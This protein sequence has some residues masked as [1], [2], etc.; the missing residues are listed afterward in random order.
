MSWQRDRTLHPAELDLLD[1]FAVQCSQALQRIRATERERTATTQVRQLAEE[2]QQ[3]LLTPPPGPDHLHVVV[4]YRPAADQAQVG[5]DWYDAFVQPDGA[6][7]LVIGDVVGHDAAAAARMGQL[8]G[9]LRALAYDADG[10]GHD[11][12]AGVLTR[13][14]HAAR[15]LAVDTLATAVL[16]RVERE[17]N[18]AVT[19]TRTVRWSNAGHLPPV[20]VH[21]DG[22]SE[23]L[24]TDAD[25]MLGVDAGTPRTDHTVRLPDHATLLLFTDGLVERRDASLDRGLDALGA[26]VTDLGEAPLD[27]LCDTL[28]ARLAPHAGDD[29]IALVAVRGYPENRPRS[30]QAAPNRTPALGRG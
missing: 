27:K 20:L 15:G 8:R 16:A 2:L 7:M 10:T 13:V 4:R 26:A 19:G 9:L 21:P 29:D 17:P 3:A 14:E 5:G 11:T 12:P 23:V 30:P 18:V 1:G 25:L 28:L 6:T 24:D 22:T